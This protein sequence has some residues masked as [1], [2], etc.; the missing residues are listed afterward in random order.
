MPHRAI[1]L[2]G[3]VLPADLAYGG[4]IQE[5]GPDVEAVAKDLALYATDEPPPD[6]TLD[7]EVEG[8]LRE[9]DERG[10]ERFHLVGYS[11]GGAAGLAF[12]ARHPDRVSS[13]TLMEP[14]WAGS[15]D[16]SPAEQALW[17]E[18]A[19]I[20]SLPAEQFMAAF[21]RLNLRPGVEPPPPPSGDPPPWMTKRPPGLRA[22][23]RA[24]ESYDLDRDAL[25]RFDRPVH[26]VLGALSNPDQ[27]QEIATRLARVFGD[28]TL[29]VYDGRHHFDPPHR[30]E[31][32]RLARSLRE[33]WDRADA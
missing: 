30:A 7:H 15:W 26:Y 5:L 1:L 9:A 25:A 29:E 24:F 12:T 13:L 17:R 11:G 18:G 28:F 20:R 19:R 8:V 16:Q 3:A 6:Y 23:T 4:L 33:L 10:W 31:P 32:G 22:L 2:P 27:Y 14:A 21:M